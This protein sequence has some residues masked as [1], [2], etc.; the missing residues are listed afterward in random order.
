MP[1]CSN[2]A[3]T[4]PPCLQMLVFYTW[5][6]RLLADS[7]GLFGSTEKLAWLAN[8]T[9]QEGGR[10]APPALL[11]SKDAAGKGGCCGGSSKKDPNDSTGK[12]L[13]PAKV[14]FRVA[15]V[16]V[17][18]LLAVGLL[19]AGPLATK[20]LAGFNNLMSSSASKCNGVHVSLPQRQFWLR[21]FRLAAFF[22]GLHQ[23]LLP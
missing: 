3:A 15:A 13:P 18:C 21:L 7:I 10:L 14:S 2:R 23:A 1:P 4:C 17:R 5:S 11:E 9:P 16:A 12:S 19:G 6:I 22:A 20:R 8:H